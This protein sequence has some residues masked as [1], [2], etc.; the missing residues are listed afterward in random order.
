MQKQFGATE[1]DVTTTGDLGTALTTN[2]GLAAT[3]YATSI[4][5]FIGSIQPTDQ[6]LAVV[7]YK[8]AIAT[9]SRGGVSTGDELQNE[10]GK[11]NSDIDSYTDDTQTAQSAI[12]DNAGA[13]SNGAYTITLQGEVKRGS[14]NI[15]IGGVVTAIDN[16]EGKIF[17]GYIDPDASS[18]DYQSGTLVIQ[19]T[20]A[21]GAGLAV[22]DSID[23][24]YTQ[25]LFGSE[26]IP[27]FKYD[28]RPEALPVRYWP[29][30]IT[31][32]AVS[33][34]VTRRRF[35][36]A[37]NELAQKDLIN[38][39]N[40][41]V[42]YNAVKQLRAAAIKNETILGGSVS[43][44]LVPPA[45]TSLVE[46][47]RTFEDVYDLATSRMEEITGLGG[48]SAIICGSEG[49]KIFKTLGLDSKTNKPG[50]YVVG[51]HDGIPV[52]YAPKDFI[53]ANEVLAIFKGDD[54]FE[55]PLVY[56]PFLPVMTVTVQGRDHNVFQTST[57]VAH[58][59]AIK[60][61]NGGFAMR[62]ILS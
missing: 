40:K 43:W 15:S 44:S 2:L 36:T 37:I 46:H 60:A 21:A 30:Q 34:F 5:P 13:P 8:R 58:G 22:G 25:L 47:R 38:Q 9:S 14:V 12:A 29:L 32:D 48:V 61:V 53:P 24:V 28:L 17:G 6:E 3:Q 41:A 7:Y 18:V 26:T 56:A 16:G 23:V 33:D 1:S 62:V 39:V 19:L 10:F 35:G 57:G 49:R 52:I 4:I 55:T 54:L 42:S 59:A 50:V 20:D 31:Y 45:G 11:V 27:G 51:F